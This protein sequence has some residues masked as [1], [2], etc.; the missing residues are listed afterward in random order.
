MD[1]AGSRREVD[2]GVA[3]AVSMP[4]VR[5]ELASARSMAGLRTLVFL[6]GGR[7]ACKLEVGCIIFT[8]LPEREN[9]QLVEYG[10]FCE[11]FTTQGLKLG[12][13]LRGLLLGE[14]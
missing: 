5:G 9:T 13:P 11:S 2:Q 10:R 1:L 6:P 12:I 14:R 8:W 4:A 3:W 7:L